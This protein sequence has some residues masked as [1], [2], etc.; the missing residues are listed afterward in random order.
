MTEQ[1]SG[2]PWIHLAGNNSLQIMLR[3][4]LVGGVPQIVGS[5]RSRRLPDSVAD[6]TVCNPMLAEDQIDLEARC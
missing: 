5:A 6:V 1:L 3:G 4:F 2:T